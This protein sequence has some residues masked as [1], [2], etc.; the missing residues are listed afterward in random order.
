MVSRRYSGYLADDESL[1]RPQMRNASTSPR[2]T[3]IDWRNVLRPPSRGLDRDTTSSVS[4]VSAPTQG[5]ERKTRRDSSTSRERRRVANEFAEFVDFLADEEVLD[6]LQDIVEDAVRKLCKVTNEKGEHVFDLREES[7]SSPDSAAWSF[8]YS[9]RHGDSSSARSRSKYTTTTIT[10]T[11]ATSSSEEDWERQ[12]QGQRSP[13]GRKVCL[14]DKYAARIPKQEK[15]EDRVSGGFHAEMFSERAGDD[16][17]F[18]EEH[19][20]AWA[21]LAESF[22]FLQGPK[23][24]YFSKFKKP[25]PSQSL[26]AESL[27]K[28]ITNVLKRPT[29]SSLLLYHPGKQPFEAL[30]FLEENKILAALQDIIN[31]AVHKVLEATSMTEGL[32]LFNI[33]DE[34]G[35]P[36][37]WES[38]EEEGSEEGEEG[39]EGDEGSGSEVTGSGEETS[40]GDSKSED[41]TSVDG[42][43]KKK[44][45]KKKG[46]RKKKKGAAEAT[47]EEKGKQR[48]T[49]PKLPKSKRK[50]GAPEEPQRKPK[51]V[52]PPLPKTKPRPPPDEPAPKPKYVPPPL[53]K[54]R[55]KKQQEAAAGEPE[56]PPQK[57]LAK[58]IITSKDIKRARLEAR[59]PPKQ[60]I[61]D[62]L[63]ENA[64][65]LILYKYN[66]ET[67]LSEK[68]GMISVPVTKVLLEIMFGY[69]RIKGSGIRLSSQIDWTRVYEE[70]YAPCPRRPKTPKHK[71]GDKKKAGEKKDGDKKKVGDK[72]GGPGPKRIIMKPRLPMPGV[73]VVVTKTQVKSEVV[74]SKPQRK[75]VI[76]EQGISEGPEIYEIV[77]PQFPDKFSEQG[78]EF[79]EGE[80]E[81]QPSTPKEPV[82]PTDDSPKSSTKLASGPPGSEEALPSISSKHSLQRANVSHQ[83]SKGSM[84]ALPEVEPAGQSSGELLKKASSSRRPSFGGESSKKSS[85]ILPKI[86]N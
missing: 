60:A 6:S 18:R 45:R 53:P 71:G 74:S 69:K 2:R 38:S 26:S 3:S 30:D 52:P 84:S 12:W 42:K 9:H 77:P 39:D 83:S 10:T 23:R 49:P 20:H 79:E 75:E 64:A 41:G 4:A 73:N 59:P 85:T 40:E 56:A 15:A 68:L 29:P 48:Y 86:S 82:T 37:P 22:Q 32:P 55:Q 47:E 24:D 58:H 34:H 1:R 25:A 70:I 44:K 50:A 11:T 8:S 78:E 63:I 31:Q 62:F 27:H 16:Y 46:K 13:S 7:S 5:S 80:S 35:H 14:L 28:E 54:P 51:Y 43:K 19:F 72:K 66:Y 61:I 17:Y 21:R 33:F 57:L 36:L 67:L 65:K 81:I 76:P